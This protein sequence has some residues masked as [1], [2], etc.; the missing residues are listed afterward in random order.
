MGHP[1]R[2]TVTSV[3]LVGLSQGP[4]QAKQ[5][6]HSVQGCSDPDPGL[7]GCG[8]CAAA[9]SY[10]RSVTSRRQGGEASH[11]HTQWKSPKETGSSYRTHKNIKSKRVFSVLG[12]FFCSQ[13]TFKV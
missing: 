8:L 4:V 2:L 13:L 11:K 5:H 10:C 6:V 9:L 7:P 12:L 3:P 1:Q